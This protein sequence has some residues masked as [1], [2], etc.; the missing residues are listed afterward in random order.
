MI[1]PDFSLAYARLS[2][3]YIF[4]GAVGFMPNKIAYSKAGEYAEKSY[5]L[6]DSILDTR[7]ARGMVEYFS[8]LGLGRC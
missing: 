8:P 5:E 3:C 2:A 4:L 6:D 1:S 7:L